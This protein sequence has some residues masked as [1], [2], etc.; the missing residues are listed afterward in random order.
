M[1]ASTRR[2]FL[3]L[4][5]LMAAGPVLAVDPNCA[6]HPP[7]EHDPVGRDRSVVLFHNAC[8]MAVGPGCH[9]RANPSLL[10]DPAQ[11]KA[12]MD[13]GSRHNH[14]RLGEIAEHVLAWELNHGCEGN[15]R[16]IATHRDLCLGRGNKL[17][18]RRRLLRCSQKARDKLDLWSA[19]IFMSKTAQSD[20]WDRRFGASLGR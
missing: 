19:E 7:E 2:M 1:K 15:A 17:Q 9:I 12:C 6:G 20:E 10:T 14:G 16:C 4:G 13:G 8:G 3:A 5:L 18:L 11:L